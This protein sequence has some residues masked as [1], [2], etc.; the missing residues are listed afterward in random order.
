MSS[1]RSVPRTTQLEPTETLMVEDLIS[2]NQWDIGLLT[3]LLDVN[4]IRNILKI[5]ISNLQV[6][7]R[8]IWLQTKSRLHSAKSFYLV[9][10]QR[11]FNTC[12]AT[13]WNKLWGIKIHD[14]LKLLLW[15]IVSGALLWAYNPSGLYAH[16]VSQHLMIL[17]IFSA[18]DPILG[19]P[20][21]VRMGCLQ[22]LPFELGWKS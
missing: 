14:R 4:S 22:M 13:Y 17:S 12:H 15:R 18:L 11:R 2:G 7:D 5:S 3:Q 9:D 6:S 1:F 21:G 8:F 20:G 19:Y 16:F 10:Q